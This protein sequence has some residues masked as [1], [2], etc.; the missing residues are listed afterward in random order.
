[1][2][3][4]WP[5]P[6][7]PPT[8][9]S[10]S[11]WSEASQSCPTLCNPLDCSPPGSS[12]HGI[13]QPRT[14]EWVAI[15]FSRGSSQP[16]DQTQVFCIASRRFNLWATREALT[17]YRIALISDV[18]YSFTLQTTL[19]IECT[20]YFIFR[21]KNG[22]SR[23]LHLVQSPTTNKRLNGRHETALILKLLCSKHTAF[24]N[25]E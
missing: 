18:P 24:Y 19:R 7:S 4:S 13:L 17:E 1:M 3:L 25:F 16:R 9:S 8:R 23:V 20:C 12:V 22:D 6:A 5:P 10:Q 14:L 2:A 21:P 15:S 11:M